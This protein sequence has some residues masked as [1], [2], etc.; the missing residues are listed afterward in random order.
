MKRQRTREAERR[1]LRGKKEKEES[2]E[3]R[4]GAN[5]RRRAAISLSPCDVVFF[6]PFFFFRPL[7]FPLSQPLEL[8]LSLRNPKKNAN[9]AAPAPRRRSRRAQ[10]GD[11]AASPPSVAGGGGVL[12]SSPTSARRRR[13]RRER[14]RRRQRRRR[15]LFPR[16]PATAATQPHRGPPASWTRGELIGAGAF[17]R[18]YLGLDDETG[19]LFAVKTV[20]LPSTVSFAG[21]AAGGGGGGASSSKMRGGEDDDESDEAIL[22]YDDDD[23]FEEDKR[24]PARPPASPPAAGRT[25]AGSPPTSR[26]CGPR[27]SCWQGSTTRT[28]SGTW[29]RSRGLPSR[30]GVPAGRRRGRG[31]KGGGNGGEESGDESEG[32]DGSGGGSGGDSP[33]GSALRGK[34]ASASSKKLSKKKSGSK[35]SKNAGQNQNLG[36]ELNIFL[37]YV[38]GGSI[39]GLVS[40]FGALA[41]RVSASYA[42][43]ILTGLAYLHAHGI[44]HRD[45]KGANCLVG[46]QGVVK[47]ADFGASKRI[48]DVATLGEFGGGGGGV[49]SSSLLR[50]PF[51]VAFFASYAAAALLSFLLS[52]S[53]STEKKAPTRSRGE[54]KTSKK[55]TET[56][57]GFNSIKGTPY[58]MAPEVIKQTGAG[59][60]ADVWSVGCTVIEMVTGRPPWSERY[61]SQVSALFAIAQA[62]GPPPLPATL[63]VALRDFLGHCLRRDPGQR[64]PARALLDHPWITGRVPAEDAAAGGRDA[65]RGRGREPAEERRRWSG[66]ERSG[67][68]A[69]TAARPRQPGSGRRGRS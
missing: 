53:A 28:S 5:S 32:D 23:D 26:R 57:G 8:F 50:G 61:G 2:I 25:T 40:R 36:S 47:L 30:R 16:A 15:S 7:P 12:L 9:R 69:T 41:E 49:V 63:S 17:G 20:S 58:W 67:E 62:G 68:V 66:A 45:V 35:G 46:S 27:S 55:K 31:D 44:A 38:P 4:P 37:E 34:K 51:P 42:R 54:K 59:R 39:A 18:V 6:L 56:G 65:A 10:G 48:E 11:D 43:Q 33:S 64:P 1:R 60:A 3:K 29:A 14:R 13:R 52:F 19:E 22:N 24:P 21:G